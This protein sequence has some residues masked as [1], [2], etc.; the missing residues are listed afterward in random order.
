MGRSITRSMPSRFLHGDAFMY[1]KSF[2]NGPAGMFE[3]D[4]VHSDVPVPSRGMRREDSPMGS[5]EGRRLPEENQDDR[6]RVMGWGPPAVKG[7]MGPYGQSTGT[8]WA[9]LY[10]GAGLGF[11]EVPRM[12]PIR[13]MGK[14]AL[15]LHPPDLPLISGE[16]LPNETDIY[17]SA[18]R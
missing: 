4:R 3:N 6:N 7:R 12:R 2:L 10:R 1:G 16:I 5:T 15:L 9:R 14:E 17:L 18:L 8:R 11:H 13:I